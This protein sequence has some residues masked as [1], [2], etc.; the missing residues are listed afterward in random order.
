[1]THSEPTSSQMADASAAESLP[2]T[3]I[4]EGPADF[5]DELQALAADAAVPHFY[6]L[7]GQISVADIA[8]LQRSYPRR[9]PC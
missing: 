7:L 5:F 4:P 2:A 1:M 6:R 8:H 3:F 9:P